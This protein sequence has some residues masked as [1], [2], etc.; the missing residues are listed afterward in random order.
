MSNHT[1]DVD[2]D[3]RQTVT[4][5]VWKEVWDENQDALS[6]GQ[7]QKYGKLF[8]DFSK[9]LTNNDMLINKDK[10]ETELKNFY[11]HQ[12]EVGREVAGR[13]VGENMIYKGSAL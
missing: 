10:Q 1:G 8:D 6:V 7:Q 11:D 2:F 13:V 5:E 12:D 4:G 3:D 9:L